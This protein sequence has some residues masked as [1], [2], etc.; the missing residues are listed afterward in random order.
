MR[1]YSFDLFVAERLFAWS[2]FTATGFAFATP[3]FRGRPRGTGGGS[4][5]GCSSLSTSAISV[6]IETVSAVAS[7]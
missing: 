1:D 2:V 7:L 5:T 3:V 6:A 4:S